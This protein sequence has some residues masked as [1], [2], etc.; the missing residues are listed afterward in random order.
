MTKRIFRSILLVALAV[1]VACFG[2]FLG[3][4]Y[5]YFGTIQTDQLRAALSITAVGTERGG[6]DYLNS[7]KTGDYRLT[8][9]AADGSVLFD[10][11]SDQSRME[12]H[13]QREEIQQAFSTGAGESSRYSSTLMEQTLYIANKLTDGTVLRIS[14]SRMTTLSLVVSMLQPV[15]MVLAIA[16]VLS[17]ILASGLSRKIVRPLEAINF[18][19][20]L[21][22]DTYEELTPILTRMEQQHS[23]IR[24]QRKEL[25]ERKNEFY[26]VISKMN[27]GL[28]L[29]GNRDEILSINPAAEK[30]FSTGG[31]S[32]GKDFIVVERSTQITDAINTAKKDGYAE[33][34]ISRKGREYLLRASRVEEAGGGIVLLV[35]D[36]TERVFAERNRR[37]FTANVSHEL[38]TPL[39]TIMGSAELLENNLVKP[40]DVPAFV[41]RIRREAGRLVTLIDDI[42]RLSQL[43]E[44]CAIPTEEVELLELVNNEIAALQSVA[45]PRKIS[46][47]VDGEPTRMQGVRQLLHE[48]IYNLCE[49]AIKYNVD[50]GSV[51]VTVGTQE[52][53]A[54]VRVK[55][56]GIGIAPEHQDRI[57]E[58]FY[59]VDKS[60]SRQIGGTGLGLSIVKHAAEY[61][62]GQITLN[63]RPGGGTEITVSFPQKE[64]GMKSQN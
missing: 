41:G 35:F 59:R 17:G 4:L 29:L 15:C 40:E 12:N 14:V 23:L 53:R 50:G 18:D 32:T 24:N 13:G 48:I 45:A 21:E 42:I 54:F 3:V 9:V 25:Q 2:L 20:P 63:S 33:L 8:W 52:E 28:V 30:F 37:E 5:E 51:R 38:K 31:D 61:M 7:L 10:N 19:R 60:H 26:A 57:F 56:T 39:Q 64:T 55:D 36:I 1:L 47:Q 62:N 44:A 58:R 49:N 43:D 11:Q 34:Q 16:L 27:E 46:L 6:L 22:N